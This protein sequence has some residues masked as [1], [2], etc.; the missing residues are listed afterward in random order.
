MENGGNPVKKCF[1]FPIIIVIIS[2][3]ETSLDE[4][5]NNVGNVFAGIDTLQWM[6]L[7]IYS[8]LEIIVLIINAVLVY[9][10][11][12]E[13]LLLPNNNFACLQPFGDNFVE[14]VT[15]YCYPRFIIAPIRDFLVRQV[16]GKD[17]R[18]LILSYLS[19]LSSDETIDDFVQFLVKYKGVSKDHPSLIQQIIAISIGIV[20]CIIHRIFGCKIVFHHAIILTCVLHYIHFAML[21]LPP[22]GLIFNVLALKHPNSTVIEF[23]GCKL[24]HIIVILFIVL[25]TSIIL[26][27]TLILSITI[28]KTSVIG[29]LHGKTVQMS[30]LANFA[31]INPEL[32]VSDVLCAILA[33]PLNT[34]VRMRLIALELA[35]IDVVILVLCQGMKDALF[36][37]IFG[38][39]MAGIQSIH[40]M[41][42]MMIEFELKLIL[43][44][45]WLLFGLVQH[46]GII[47]V[48]LIILVGVLIPHVLSFNFDQIAMK[49]T[50]IYPNKDEIY[51]EKYDE[52]W[53][54]RVKVKVEVFI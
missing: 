31:A 24:C 46:V 5:N 2:A 7:V 21:G 38:D 9:K 32:P 45:K 16:F 23:L 20:S 10:S 42:A 18:N 11:Y 22:M 34:F 8:T 14:Y 39:I 37:L 28:I 6:M 29:F 51:I 1:L 17:V 49:L 19:D 33:I 41:V 50:A 53:Y 40:V 35:Q 13:T 15:E 44:L 36:G 48:C 47:F 12:Y 43:L 25:I 52:Y 26:I 30:I 54:C 3:I 27:I 4:N